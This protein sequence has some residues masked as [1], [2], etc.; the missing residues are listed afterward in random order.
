ML[1]VFLRVYRITKS[2]GKIFLQAIADKTAKKIARR[3]FL[4]DPVDIMSKPSNGEMGVTFTFAVFSGEL[5]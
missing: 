4:H 2:V 3:L 5:I 1:V